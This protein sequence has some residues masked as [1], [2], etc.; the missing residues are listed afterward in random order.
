M[1]GRVST[2]HLIFPANLHGAI[3][4]D[5]GAPLAVVQELKL[6]AR[7]PAG[8]QTRAQLLSDLNFFRRVPLFRQLSDEQ[9]EIIAERVVIRRFMR[10]QTVVQQGAKEDTLFILLSG[11]AR[12][13]VTN[14]RGREVFLAGLG[15]GDFF[16]EMS[17]IDGEPHSATVRT[18]R[19]ADVLILGRDD[20]A[21]CLVQNS[22]LAYTLMRGLVRRL[23]GANKQIMSLA[24][25]DVS[26]RVARILLDSAETENG[27]TLIRQRVS[28]TTLAKSTGASREMVSRAMRQ[29]EKQ[30]LISIR[31]DGALVIRG[32]LA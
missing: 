13:L 15:P 17:L 32:D 4:H 23:R 28:R 31:A 21:R 6:V 19:N 26:G 29:F 18:E 12:V 30:G 3:I 20:L 22:S 24:L 7:S 1:H 14:S 8:K 27:V 16:G 11:E 9:V 10:G 25:L 5:A 2:A